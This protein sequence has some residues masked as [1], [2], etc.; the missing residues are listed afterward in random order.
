MKATTLLNAGMALAI[1]FVSY[2]FI[3]KP[4]NKTK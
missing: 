3:K 1:L 2:L 4:K